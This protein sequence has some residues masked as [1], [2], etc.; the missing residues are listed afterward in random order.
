MTDTLG[1]ERTST[2]RPAQTITYAFSP[3]VLAAVQLLTVPVHAVG[4][5]R[6]LGWGLIAVA[7]VSVAPLVY[8]LV[9]VRRRSLTDV[10]IG[11]REH[12][13]VPFTVGLVTVAVGLALLT[14]TGAPR[15]LLAVVAAFVIL[16]IVTIAITNWWK[17]SVH[18]MVAMM[19]T[20]IM[21]AVYGPAL[22]STVVIVAVIGWARVKLHDHTVGQVLAGAVLGL[23]IAGL[24]VLMR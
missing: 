9:R 13:R 23:G 5:L 20:G 11:T 1:A 8:V 17:I 10:H 24:F 4:L 6:G 15:D 2:N 18:A 22:L 19:T 16:T 14:V 21:A 12:R 3:V 7:F